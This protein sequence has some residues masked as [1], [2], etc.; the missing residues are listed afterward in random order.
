MKTMDILELLKNYIIL[1]LKILIPVAIIFFI[2]YGLIYKKMIKGTKTINKSKILL[3]AISICYIVI[4]IGATFFS[5]QST[6]TYNDTFNLNLFSS[7]REAYHDI[8]VSVLNNIL[9]RNLILNIMLFIP[10]G[11]LLPL[12]SDKLKKMYIVVPIGLLATLM[13]EFTQHFNG[14]GTFEI[15]DVFNNTLGTFLGYCCFMIFFKIKNKENWKKIIG[16]I[17][18]IVLTIGAFIGILAIYQLQEFGNF[19]FEYNYE[20]NMKNVNVQSEV[21]FSKDKIVKDVFHINTLTE[22]E[23]KQIA[24]ELFKRLGKKIDDNETMKSQNSIIYWSEGRNTDGGDAVRVEINYIGG[25]YQYV[26]ETLIVNDAGTVQ[27]LSEIKN[28]SRKEIVNALEKLGIIINENAKFEMNKR[29]QYILSVD[30]EPIDNN[31]VLDGTL[32]CRY[33]EDHT[34]RNVTNNI[35]VYEKITEKEIISE[36]EAYEEIL[37]GRFLL[38]NTKIES[39][40]IK[41]INLEYKVDSKGYYVPIYE[42]EVLVNGKETKIYI[43]AIK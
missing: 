31:K 23:T 10:L 28:A 4:V 39:I 2:V 15:D 32:T 11:F 37:K 16:Y 1:G 36:E 9:V 38:S 7:Y 30:M 34:I 42:F 43:K 13:I 12:Y 25:T 8:G 40:T 20:I 6:E 29:N 41:D 17:I 5:R 19:E 33:Y 35:S 22:T 21:D 18:P 26:A 3:C 14:Y 27:F 24:N